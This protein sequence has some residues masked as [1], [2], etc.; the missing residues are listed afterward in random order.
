MN[1]NNKDKKRKDIL[2][3]NSLTTKV[4]GII[5]L[6]LIFAMFILG[7]IINKSVDK[8]VTQ[9][10]KTRN[11]E[12]AKGLKSEFNEYLIGIEH[13][14]RLVNSE[15]ELESN[16]LDLMKERFEEIKKEYSDFAFI[17]LG[18]NKGDMI[19]YPDADF[20]N[21]DPRTRPWY[22]KAT[23]EDK[24]IWTD[25]YLDA[26]TKKPVITVAIP[27][28]DKAGNFI[29]VLG[30]DVSLEKLSNK[31]D[32]KKIG[33]T[34][35]AYMVAKSGKMLAHPKYKLVEEGYDLNR[36]FKIKPL[37]EQGIGSLEYEDIDTKEEKLAS[38][39]KLDRINAIIFGQQTFKEV[40][41][42][43]GAL[44]NKI[45]IFSVAV[46]V[47]LSFIIYL[48][49][50][51]LLLL[52]I[53]DLIER[54]KKVANGN[55][56]ENIDIDRKDEIGLLELNFNQMKDNLK[57]LI[58]GLVDSI[59]NLSAY[60]EEL[61]ASAEEGNA[62][63]E[64]TNELIEKMSASIQQIS[65]SAQ[66][67]TSFAEEANAQTNVGRE[68]IENTVNSINEIN[69]AVEKTVKVMHEL[70]NTSEEI[71]QI[72]ELITNIA[73]QTNLL[74][75]NAAIEAARAGEH[76]QGFAVVA[77]EIRELAEETSKAT[78]DISSLVKGTQQQTK[79]GI[80][81]IT[82]VEAK[83]KEGKNIAKETDA[84]FEE[85]EESS[86]QTSAHIQQTAA[87]T[88]SLAQNSNDIMDAA[89][90]ISN[91]SHEVTNSSQELAIM[92]QK[93]QSIISEFEV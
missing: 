84:V 48:V 73:E 3:K 23:S 11:L 45:I 61:S 32:E 92:A 21:Y 78:D 69:D 49:I 42:A 7:V 80:D 77:D 64:T 18:T 9:L 70:D 40:Y 83:A 71:G 46:I 75:L 8:E 62:T 89:N 29:G 10:T 81:S 6:F 17:Y 43:R 15:T 20:S 65:A 82:K 4:N 2:L 88:Q 85:I 22:K 57:N 24:L 26:N 19:A 44:T 30:I 86:Q 28:Y 58:V 60:S 55:L 93:L 13:I 87:S 56:T 50:N 36:D 67:V 53:K 68:N 39:V 34:G 14:V 38:Y 47:I 35:Y 1:F 74:A 76:G 31:I 37:W 54:M 33:N 5:I 25:I 41:A 59:E 72:V 91:M 51:R 90:E 66:E 16:N 27:H 79:G 52:P 63:I 12:V